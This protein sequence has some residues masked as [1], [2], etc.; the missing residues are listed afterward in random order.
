MEAF[1]ER[2][3]TINQIELH[4]FNTQSSI[5][6][7]CKDNNIILQAYAPLARGM[8]FKHPTIVDLAKKYKVSPASVMIK[9]ALQ[10]DYVV[11]PKSVAKQRIVDNLKS[12]QG[13]ELE[14]GEMEKL[15]AL[16][17]HLVTGEL[18][19]NYCLSCLRNN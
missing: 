15:G 8:R 11:L 9:W 18:L 13:W 14:V 12:A 5:V 2:P 1:P 7:I 6:K 3:P 19:Y 4:P 17:E 16:D 10:E